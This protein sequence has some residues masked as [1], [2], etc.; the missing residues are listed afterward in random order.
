M[1]L[2][3]DA[4]LMLLDN[5]SSGIVVYPAVIQRPINGELPFMATEP[6]TMAMVDTNASPQEA[7]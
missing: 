4:L 5:I 6:V 7:H 2:L 1:F 3:V